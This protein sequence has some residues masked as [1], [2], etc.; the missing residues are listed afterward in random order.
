VEWIV[1]VACMEMMK[2]AY[3]VVIKDPEGERP[4]RR[5]I[6]ERIKVEWI[7]MKN[8]GRGLSRFIVLKLCT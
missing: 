8:S 7:L 6:N 3:I 4:L 1:L 2:K 5:L